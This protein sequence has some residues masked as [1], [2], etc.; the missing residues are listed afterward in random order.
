MR[1]G[2]RQFF[3]AEEVAKIRESGRKKN[4]PV[5]FFREKIELVERANEEK[6]ARRPFQVGPKTQKLLGERHGNGV[7]FNE[8]YVLGVGQGFSEQGVLNEERTEIAD[9]ELAEAYFDDVIDGLEQEISNAREES[10]RMQEIRVSKKEDLEAEKDPLE[11]KRKK[12]E[13]Q[14]F[15]LEL[16]EQEETLDG[17]SETNRELRKYREL[18]NNLNR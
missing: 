9:R 17:E 8:D 2:G 16:D 5:S 10:R 3:S 18:K 7:N 12:D 13:Y 15:L 4:N 14:V 11:R 6:K 1:D